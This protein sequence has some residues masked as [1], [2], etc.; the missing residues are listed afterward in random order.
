LQNNL[1]NMMRAVV[2]REFGPVENAKLD[3]VPK[4]APKPGEVLLE[5]HATA[6]NFVDLI[7]MSGKY[8]FK[9]ELPFVPG[10]MPAGVVAAIG[11]GVTLFKPGDHAIAMA[12]QAGFAEFIAMPESQC[13]KLPAALPLTEAAAM[14]LVYDT[15]WFALR[16]RARIAPGETV[17][18]LGA[19]GGVGLAAVQLAKAFGARVLGGVASADKADIVRA[20]GA[21]AIIDLAAPDLNEALRAQVSAQTEKRGTDIILDMLG[22]DIFDAAIRALAWRGRLVVIGFAAGRIPTLKANYLL[23]KNIEVSGLQVSDYRKRMPKEMQA[24][25]AEI[26]ALHAAGK[27]KPLPTKTYP[28]AQF[29]AAMRDIQD[30]KVRGRV[31]L[32]MRKD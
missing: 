3:E 5:I 31:V 27:L 11:A 1:E 10:K 20:A 32:T 25:F 2:V 13:V 14:A 18:V 17:L 22:G 29:A 8:Q 15:A 26:F 23:L 21:D 6:V 24:C 19:T 4:P 16:D 7:M 9:P 30:R 28:L 12:E